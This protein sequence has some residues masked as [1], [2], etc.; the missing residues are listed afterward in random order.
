MPQD[1]FHIRRLADELNTFL[2]GGK[3]NRI[4]QVDKDE[5]TLVIYAKKQVSKLILSTNASNARVCLSKPH[6]TTWRAYGVARRRQWRVA[7]S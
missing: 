1:A 4:S 2:V 6:V 7:A 5:L 3:I